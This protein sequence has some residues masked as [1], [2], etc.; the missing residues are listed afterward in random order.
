[1]IQQNDNWRPDIIVLG[2]GGIKGFLEL[3]ALLF[4]EERGYLKNVS[5]YVG[6]SIGAIISFLLVVGYKVPEI[7]K[8]SSS[9]NVFHEISFLWK[10]DVSLSQNLQTQLTQI[11]NHAGILPN[12]F[13]K[14]KL[15]ELVKQKYG[16][17]PTLKQ[18]KLTTGLTL[19]CVTT[20]LTLRRPE[21][22]NYETD[23]DLMCIDPVL[24]SANIPFIFYKLI[25]KGNIYVDG[26]LSDPYPVNH[27]DHK[28]KNILGLHIIRKHQQEVVTNSTYIYEVM[29][30]SMS[31]LAKR[32]KESASERCRHIE[33][34]SDIIDTLGLTVDA[35]AKA[36]MI[37]EGYK[38]SD[39][40]FNP[41]RDKVH[42]DELSSD[43]E[44]EGVLYTGSESVPI[45]S[46][47]D[48][49]EFEE[50][51]K[52]SQSHPNIA[53]NQDIL[54]NTSNQKSTITQLEGK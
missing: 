10:H 53:N 17:I 26:A 14:D 27:Y 39:R 42:D 1:M 5:T 16:Y 30:F 2:P 33:L 8:I 32:S 21:Y 50:S 23:P 45:L 37:L 7:I 43:S 15:S 24:M 47:E 20:N 3:G 41:S 11:N 6:V 18:L 9:F 29:D 25:H 22:I 40:F 34:V 12:T 48:A 52:S 28:G 49:V 19:T 38:T 54:A 13:I 51:P 36:N 4:L 46:D 31:Q 44:S 35:K